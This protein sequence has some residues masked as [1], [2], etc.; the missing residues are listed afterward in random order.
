MYNIKQCSLNIPALFPETW[1]KQI[2]YKA[3]CTAMYWTDQHIYVVG[4]ARCFQSVKAVQSVQINDWLTLSRAVLFT[5][6]PTRSNYMQLG[7]DV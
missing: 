2:L 3:L 5:Y 1:L 6:S 4:T 7:T